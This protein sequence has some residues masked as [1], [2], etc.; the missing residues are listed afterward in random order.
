MAFEVSYHD[1]IDKLQE[2][3][4]NACGPFDRLA[5][6]ELLAGG[7]SDVIIVEAA[8]TNDAAAMILARSGRGL[9]SLTNWF[10]FTWRPIGTSLPALE[11]MARALRG[12]TRQIVLAPLPDE[13]G[14]ASLLEK[15]FRSAGWLVVREHCDE[16]HILPV[17]GR[18]FA[19]YWSGRP[20]RL[21]TTLKRKRSK[22]T[23]EIFDK[24]DANHWSRYKNIYAKSWKPAEERADLLESFARLEGEAG[25]LRLGIAF[26]DGEPVAAQFWTVDGRTAYIHKLAHTETGAALSAGTVLSAAMFE[27]VIDRDEVTLV[28]FGTGSDGYKADWMEQVRPRFR[29]TCYDWRVP[30]TWFAIAKAAARRLARRSPQG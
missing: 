18:S 28:D 22:L 29:L 3:A 9:A 11:A 19:E 10:S 7:R 17:D 2:V 5:W 21:R 24:F 30:G 14:T 15:A 1:R 12:R 6:F 4:A 16:N 20:G 13:D 27:H 26:A 8:G 23:I 25:R